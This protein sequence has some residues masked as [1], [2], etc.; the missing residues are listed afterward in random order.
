VNLSVGK[1]VFLPLVGP[2]GAGKTSLLRAII[3]LVRPTSGTVQ[4][5]FTQEPPG[6]VPQQGVIDPLYPVPVA[7][8]V[9]MGLYPRLGCWRRAKTQERAAVLGALE[10][11]GLEN[12][13]A[14]TFAQLSGGM[15]QK[16]LI[17]RALVARPKVLILDEPT[18][19][20][21]ETS[22][23][24]IMAHLRAINQRQGRTIIMAHHGDALLAGAAQTAYQV[25]HGKLMARSL[26]HA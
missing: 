3:G 20:L 11:V 23:R 10:Q 5:P 1:G 26:R 9:A 25:E 19:G 18:A 7:R 4:T 21:D 16:A 22:Q 6:Y 12:H 14:K 17:A 8:I 24:E 2:N 15:R 13:A